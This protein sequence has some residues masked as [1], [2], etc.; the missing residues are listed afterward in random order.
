[1]TLI[2]AQNKEHLTTNT[3]RINIINPAIEYELSIANQSVISAG[4]G[5]GFGIWYKNLTEDNETGLLLSPFL[6]LEYKNI[7][8]LAKRNSKNKKTAYNA[9]NYWGIRTLTRFKGIGSSVM[10]KD[11]IDIAIGPVWGLQRN[12]GAMHFLFDVG[13]KFYFDTKG[14]S[15]A[16]LIN[17]QVNIGWN[18]NLKR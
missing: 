18:I 17:V 11:D 7:Y 14:N 10:R 9:G 3:F 4:C 1:M 8:N 6:D 2:K 15:G 5:V 12:I 16:Y 13:P